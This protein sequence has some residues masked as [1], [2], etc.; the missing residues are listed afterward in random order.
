MSIHKSHLVSIALGHPNNKIVDVAESRT[1]SRRGLARSEPSID[2]ELLL[3][4]CLVSDE[5]KIEIQMLE[6]ASQLATWTFHFDDLGFDFD[7]D[8][9]RDVHGLR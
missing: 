6:V 5:V 9:L 2:F 1:N 4:S 8:P 7:G 3:T